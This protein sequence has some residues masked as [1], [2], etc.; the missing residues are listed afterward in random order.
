MRAGRS[1]R[2]NDDL[3]VAV[4][5]DRGD[6]ARVG[7]VVRELEAV[8]V[9]LPPDPT[10]LDRDRSA[11][12]AARRGDRGLHVDVEE[13]LVADDLLC[14]GDHD[15]VRVAEALWHGEGRGERAARVGDDASQD[16]LRRLVLAAG[17]LAPVVGELPCAARGR[18]DEVVRGVRAEAARRCRHLGVPWPVLGLEREG[19]G[20]LLRL[21]GG[22][23]PRSSRAW[24]RPSPVAV[25][26]RCSSSVAWCRPPPRAPWRRA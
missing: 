7:V 22:R 12:R 19:A 1:G 20:D 9:R 11:D 26:S 18:P 17:V 8:L 3:A 23:P 6:P 14:V 2:R 15:V 24:P 13:R 25:R 10:H 4:G 16:L 5:R 21:E